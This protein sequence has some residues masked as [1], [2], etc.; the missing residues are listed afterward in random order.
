MRKQT[1]VQLT[2]QQFEAVKVIAIKNK[3]PTSKQALIEL[4]LKLVDDFTRVDEFE[5]ITG[6]CY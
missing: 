1:Q 5:S 3:L 6:Y 4:A 2:D